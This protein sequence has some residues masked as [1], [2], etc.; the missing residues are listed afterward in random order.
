MVGYSRLAP[1]EF[2]RL[3]RSADPSRALPFPEGALMP[4]ICRIPSTP[5]S[6]QQESRAMDE[7]EFRTLILAQHRRLFHFIRKHI[8]NPSDAEDIAQQTFIEA[9]RSLHNFRGEASATTWLFG[10]AMN[11]IRN[12]ST[13]S[14]N[15]RYEFVSDEV[16]DSVESSVDTP[17]AAAERR[18][19]IKFLDREL[20]LL[21]REMREVLVLVC[22][23]GVSYQDAAQILGIPVGTVRSRVSRARAHLRLRLAGTFSDAEA[24][25]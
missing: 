14:L 1:L 7:H 11:L 10:I 6:F 16:L 17:A 18:S 2:S 25:K 8:K 4:E 22:M 9:W 24:T 20:L 3:P 15:K 5:R 12:F 19:T 21:D 13:R 23:E